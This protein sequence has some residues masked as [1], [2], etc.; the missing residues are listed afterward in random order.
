[1]VPSMGSQ[2]VGHNLESEQQQWCKEKVGRVELTLIKK[3]TLHL[4]IPQ[5]VWC[6]HIKW[7]SLESFPGGSDDK[8]TACSARD[9]DLIPGWGRFPGEENGNPLQYS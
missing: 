2:R 3:L 5:I 7:W 4:C 9:L 8:E 1:M 6:V